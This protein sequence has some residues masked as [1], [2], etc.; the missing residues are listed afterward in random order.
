ML[1]IISGKS[2]GKKYKSHRHDRKSTFPL[3]PKHCGLSTLE[4]G[5]H[6]CSATISEM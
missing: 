1:F 2:A 3:T 4:H 5:A 6:V